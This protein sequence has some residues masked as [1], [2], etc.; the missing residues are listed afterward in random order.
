MAQAVAETLSQSVGQTPMHHET[1]GVQAQHDVANRGTAMTPMRYAK[2]IK[3]METVNLEKNLRL[4]QLRFE[5]QNMQKKQ[6]QNR[7]RE[8]SKQHKSTSSSSMGNIGKNLGSMFD[9]VASG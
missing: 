8:K 2:E 9:S 7:E 1:V 6:L 4:A 3:D 5:G